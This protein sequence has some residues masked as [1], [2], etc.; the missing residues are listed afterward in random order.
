MSTRP[1]SP[2]PR[3]WSA[4]PLHPLLLAAFPV[5]FLF[6]ENAVQQVT[7]DPLWLPLGAAV[8][9]AA[10]AMV[11]A[12]G[13][14]RDWVRGALLAS[15]LVALFF[16]FGH[17]WNVTRQSFG[18]SD[19]TP[20]AVAYA[21]IALV[22][23]LG[24]AL[25]GRRRSW[26]VSLTGAVNV[27]AVLLFAFNVVRV[28]EFALGSTPALPAGSAGTVPIATDPSAIER[29]PDIYYIILDRY[30]NAE[31][32]D[33]IYGFDNRPFLTELE[34]RG[35]TVAKDSWANYFKTSLSLTS[36]L[37]MEPLDGN[38]LKEG[39][40]ASFEPLHRALRQRL[41]APATLKSLGYEYVHIANTWEP[42]AT[43]VDADR[44]LRW[45]EGS[46]FSSAVLSTTAWSLTEPYVEPI[47]PE[48]PGEG[49][50]PPDILRA[51]T[52]FQFD[53]LEESAGR[54]G[55][56]FVFAHILLPHAPWRFNADGSFPTPEQVAR[57]S[58]NES[59]LEHLRYANSRV[60]TVLD[61]LLAV[62]PGEEPVII[63]QADE[64]EFPIEFA[65]NQ[66]RFNWL[67]ATPDQIQH[68]F[69][70][71]NAFHLPGVD[72]TAAG[73]HDRITPV[74]AFRIVFNAYF[75]AALPL[76]P[77]TTYL[78]PDYVRMFDFV[79]Y[80]RPPSGS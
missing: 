12:A 39:G 75:D 8:G 20:L 7:L 63:L 61:R 19:R 18:L 72:A 14:L 52:L 32:L 59:Y 6:A 31:T 11:L 38:A 17:V 23:S 78:S 51:H 15:L 57:R 74:N 29:R 9:G 76:L 24:L 80:E 46:G 44:V 26:I 48:D 67:A 49:V 28:G 40:R 1:G 68:K 60:L 71:L 22:A 73:V 42:T 56:T 66:T 41:A 47:E 4:V 13:L 64:G 58:R 3:S 70:I 21:V 55:P 54:P 69:G 77:D 16:S 30:S 37:S 65:R 27:V 53:R 36:S 2:Q 33:R 50:G 25:A 10:V 34:Q 62:P 45:S 43:N 35:F 5:L 79:P